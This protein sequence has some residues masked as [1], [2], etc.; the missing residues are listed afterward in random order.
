GS[1][2]SQVTTRVPVGDFVAWATSGMT[3]W[4]V[5]KASARNAGPIARSRTSRNDFHHRSREDLGA[6]A[7]GAEAAPGEMASFCRPAEIDVADT[8]TTK[9]RPIASMRL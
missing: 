6:V 3:L 4:V 1:G 2:G 9:A 7:V 8:T 5:A